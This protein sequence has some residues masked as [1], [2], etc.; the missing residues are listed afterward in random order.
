[1]RAGVMAVMAVIVKK[2]QWRVHTRGR[3]TSFGIL[4]VEIVI[5]YNILLPY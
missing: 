3:D 1:M 4:F 5:I 2:Y